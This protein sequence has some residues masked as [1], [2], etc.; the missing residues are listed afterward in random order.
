MRNRVGSATAFN[1]LRSS[2]ALMSLLRPTLG[3]PALIPSI[4]GVPLESLQSGE[5]LGE[6]AD[7]HVGVLGQVVDH[8]LL[9]VAGHGEVRVDARAQRTTVHRVSKGIAV[10]VGDARATLLRGG[11]CLH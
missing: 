9:L 1:A 8:P 10:H 3:T 7:S 5:R 11:E 4:A 2:F 6:E